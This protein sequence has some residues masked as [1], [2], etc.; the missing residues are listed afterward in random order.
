MAE[1]PPQNYANHRKFVPL[2]HFVL[3]AVLVV[4][5]LW[6]VMRAWR[7]FSFE[8]A[9]GVV[10]AL[11]LMVLAFF[12]RGFP[13]T[14]QDR[15]IRLEMRLRLKDILPTDLRGRIGELTPDQ[16]IGLRFASDAE[17]PDLVRETLS[18]NIQD[19]DVIK[20][21]VRDWQADHLRC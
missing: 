18:N 20:R 6:C 10:M 9:W 4:N 3:F 8:T 2:Y 19:R 5:L 12:L 7:G 14:V 16:L 1:K 13:L 15:V 11:A 17:L 21:K